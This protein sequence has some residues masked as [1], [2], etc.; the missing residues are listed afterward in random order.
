MQQDLVSV[1]IPAYNAE[2]YVGDAINSVLNQTYPYIEIIVIDDASCDNTAG[3]VQSVKDER[4]RL[5]RHQENMGP[6]GARNTGIET[7][8]GRWIAELDAD[9]QW[10]PQRLERLLATIEAVSDSY[11]VADNFLWCFDTPKGLKPWVSRFKQ[12]KI[13]LDNSILD[14]DLAEFVKIGAPAICPIIPLKFVQDNNLRYISRCYLGEDFEFYCQL[15]LHG[16][17]LRLYGE[18]LYLRRLTPGSLTTRNNNELIGIHQR[19]LSN[20]CLS[21]TEKE[22]L[23]NNFYKI[24][25]QQ[26]F[27]NFYHTLRNRR[28]QKALLQLMLKPSLSIYCIKRIPR[29]IFYYLS[30]RRVGGRLRF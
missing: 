17:K 15:L 1:I 8:R 10:A 24:V 9:D 21:N 30:A 16:L 14:V 6:G 5:V 7:A 11:F 25:A 19:L 22:V 12:L 20:N 3:V 4:V 2:K 26:H 29:L 23:E 27:N 18:P 28:W 13:V